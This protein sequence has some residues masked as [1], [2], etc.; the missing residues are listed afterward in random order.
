MPKHFKRCQENFVCENCGAEVRGTDY[1]NHCPN[2]LWSKHVDQEVP[3]DR[4]SGCLGMMEPVGMEVKGEDYVVIHRCL[5]CRKIMK[6][7]TSADDNFEKI[8]Q[9]SSKNTQS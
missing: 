2:C 4:K 1:T 5:K 9:I 6:N 7:K 8:L 3:G